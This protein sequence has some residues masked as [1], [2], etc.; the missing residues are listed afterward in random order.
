[1]LNGHVLDLLPL[2]LL[3]VTLSLVK[4][5]LVKM[6]F[7]WFPRVLEGLLAW[8]LAHPV[9]MVIFVLLTEVLNHQLFLLQ[10]LLHALLKRPPVR[11]L[12]H[13]TL[14]AQVFIACVTHCSPRFITVIYLI[15][16]LLVLLLVLP[17]PAYL[18][19]PILHAL[20][21]SLG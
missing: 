20:H 17:H 11:L 8:I 9:N 3:I 13:S 15:H 16:G 1:M 19:Q 4:L 21:L 6:L 14:L 18:Q 10:V 5:L 12:G 7:G 2:H